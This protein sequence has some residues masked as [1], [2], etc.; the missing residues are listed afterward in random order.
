MSSIAPPALLSVLNG[1]SHGLTYGTK[2]RI[3]H[4]LVLRR[5]PRVSRVSR[6]TC[7]SRLV[8]FLNGKPNLLSAGALP[9]PKH[10]AASASPAAWAASWA[11][12]LS[13]SGASV[14]ASVGGKSL[15]S[16]PVQATRGMQVR[17]AC[18]RISGG[19]I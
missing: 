10:A 15:G 4:A 19:P 18:L 8:E 14:S 2:I 12:V 6:L 5:S 13:T 3:P 1:V 16:H 7:A 17:C 11:L 9:P